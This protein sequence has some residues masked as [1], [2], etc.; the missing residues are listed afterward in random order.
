MNGSK[1][2]AVLGLTILVS[3]V[4]LPAPAAADFHPV[5]T[6]FATGY[7]NVGLESDGDTGGL[8]Y[9][10]LVSCPDTVVTIVSLELWEEGAAEASSVIEGSPCAAGLASPC[11]LENGTAAAPGTYEV[12]M[13]FDVDHPATAH[14]DYEGVERHA[15]FQWSGEGV[16]VPTC[17]STGFFPFYV[18]C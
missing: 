17:T 3:M 15:T 8:V 12:R 6:G 10:G 5:C 1:R 18:G 2:V 16:P 7:A 11:A 14:V 4:W 13:V 9:S